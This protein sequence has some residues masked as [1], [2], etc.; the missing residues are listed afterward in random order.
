MCHEY[1]L[2]EKHGSQY[3]YELKYL[4]IIIL[5]TENLSM[6]HEYS[7]L[8]KHGPQY[9]YELKYLTIIILLTEKH[10]HTHETFIN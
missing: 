1:S 4:T 10:I 8:E 7:L 9:Y 2:L 6:C 5:L 3:Y